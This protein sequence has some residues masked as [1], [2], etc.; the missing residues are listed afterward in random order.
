MFDSVQARLALRL[1]T[2]MRHPSQPVNC[3]VLIQS[4]GANNYR[5]IHGET[6]PGKELKN[7]VLLS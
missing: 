2:K 7:K 6:C 4:P 1:N 5:A 3:V